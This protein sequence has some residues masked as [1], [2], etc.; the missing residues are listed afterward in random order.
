MQ[1]E[2]QEKMAQAETVQF[3][4]NLRRLSS[5]RGGMIRLA[6]TTKVTRVFLSQIIHGHANPSLD[7]AAKIATNLGV[8]LDDLVSK[9]LSPRRIKAI[10]AAA[11]QQAVAS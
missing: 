9:P 3:R 11:E 5:T 7:T 10:L 4:D 1:R 6:A 8:T 2:T